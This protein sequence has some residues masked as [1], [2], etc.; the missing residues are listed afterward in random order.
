M[1][2]IRICIQDR[3]QWQ[4]MTH[5]EHDTVRSL[6]AS[7]TSKDYAPSVDT[8]CAFQNVYECCCCSTTWIWKVTGKLPPSVFAKLHWTFGD[9]NIKFSVSLNSKLRD[10]YILWSLGIKKQ[11]MLFLGDNLAG[12]ACIYKAFTVE[13]GTKKLLAIII[14]LCGHNILVEME[15]KK[16][17]G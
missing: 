13:L 4:S 1:E 2:S 5:S 16:T 7:A 3:C 10:T 17:D 8:P 14:Y 11:K 12:N 15:G 6:W 9:T